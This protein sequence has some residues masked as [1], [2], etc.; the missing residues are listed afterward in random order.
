MLQVINNVS[1]FK[2]NLYK[3]QEKK[4]ETLW[5]SNCTYGKILVSFGIDKARYHGSALEGNSI[6]KIF[7]NANEIFKQFL[8]EIMTIISDEKVF[9]ILDDQINRYIEICILF[10]TL[11]SIARTP[12][13]EMDDSKLNNLNA[14]ITL[15]MLKWRIFVHLWKWLKYMELKI[16][17]LIKLTKKN[18][19]GCFIEDFIRSHSEKQ[20]C[21]L[22]I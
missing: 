21:Q 12:C 16:I 1:F 14:I 11:F 7:Q 22:R 10:D 8:I 19:I 9:L 17:Y 20:N 5:Y 4:W 3:I 6:Q 2:K 18:E 15:C 13:G